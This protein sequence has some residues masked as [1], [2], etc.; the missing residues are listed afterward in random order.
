[1]NFSRHKKQFKNNGFSKVFFPKIK[2]LFQRQ[3]ADKRIILKSYGG[4]LL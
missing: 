3:K 2:A 4:I 1:M